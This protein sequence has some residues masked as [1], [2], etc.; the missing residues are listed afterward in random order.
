VVASTRSGQEQIEEKGEVPKLVVSE[1]WMLLK[2]C[3]PL[4]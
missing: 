3:Y 1:S 4:Q 2:V